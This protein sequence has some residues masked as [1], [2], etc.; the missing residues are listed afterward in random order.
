MKKESE[1]T[2]NKMDYKSDSVRIFKCQNCNRI[3]F[4][5]GSVAMELELRDFFKLSKLLRTPDSIIKRGGN[6]IIP[7]VKSNVFLKVKNGHFNSIQTLVTQAEEFLKAE[8]LLSIGRHPNDY[9]L[10]SSHWGNSYSNV[11][12]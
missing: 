12:N 2:M 9:Y 5:Y 4:E 3:H 10:D 7:I 1:H 8:Y 6:Q 11:M